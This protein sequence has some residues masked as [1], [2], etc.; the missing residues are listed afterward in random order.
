MEIEERDSTILLTEV[1]LGLGFIG[2]LT[3]WRELM[4]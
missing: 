1:Q 2:L 4:V 3:R